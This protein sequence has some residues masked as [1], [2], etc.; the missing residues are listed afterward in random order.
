VGL[1]RR[2]KRMKV[3]AKRSIDLGD[4]KEK[5]KF[6]DMKELGKDLKNDTTLQNEHWLINDTGENVFGDISIENVKSISMLK[7]VTKSFGDLET[8]LKD[9]KEKII[10]LKKIREERGELEVKIKDLDNQEKA[11]LDSMV[12]K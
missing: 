1:S 5:M 6:I 3:L 11:L 7:D 10:H 8:E 4:D 12:L 9:F 2:S